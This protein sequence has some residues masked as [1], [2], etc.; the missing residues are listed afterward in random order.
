MVEA[1]AKLF[2]KENNAKPK[3]K[4]SI[5]SGD[6]QK[7]NRYF[8]ERQNTDGVW[9]DAEKLVEF[10]WFSLCFHFACRGR[11]GWREL[12]RQSF[13][14]KT[15]DTQEPV[16]S[17][18]NLLNQLKITKEAL[19]SLSSH[20]RMFVRT[21]LQLHLIQWLT[22][23]LIPTAMHCFR[24]QT[25]TPNTGSRCPAQA[26]QIGSMFT[27]RFHRQ[28]KYKLKRLKN[29]Q[30]EMKTQIKKRVNKTLLTFYLLLL[31]VN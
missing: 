22:A 16:T 12:T 17:P 28:S 6:M 31:D 14:I 19:N 7:L 3:H 18:K 30:V 27:R 10:I 24:L 11:E 5:Q 23:R 15:D 8:M 2:T 26:A 9:K 21:K 29:E 13:E 1:K 25:A 20:T 4:S